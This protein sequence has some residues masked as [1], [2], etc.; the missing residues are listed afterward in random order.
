MTRRHCRWWLGLLLCACGVKEQAPSTS[1][2]GRT[3]CRVEGIQAD[4]PSEILFGDLHVHSAL[5]ID[6]YLQNLP[7]GGRMP[8]QGPMDRCDFARLCAQL[9]FWSINDHPEEQTIDEWHET[10]EAIRLCNDLEGGYTARPAMVSFLGWEWTPTSPSPASDWGHK[11][12]ILRDTCDDTIVARPMSAPQTADSFLSIPEST[13]RLAT[14]VTKGTDPDNADI[15]EE[16]YDRLHRAHAVPLCEAGV[17]SRELPLDCREVADDPGVLYEKLAQWDVPAIVI[18]HGET[19]GAFHP[20]RTGWGAQ[21]NRQMHDPR[22]ERLVEIYSGHGNGEEYRSFRHVN[23]GPDGQLT[24]PEPTVE[25]EPCCYRAGEIARGRSRACREEP[26]GDKCAAEVAEAQQ[27]YVDAGLNGANS[28]PD[29]KPEEW[30]DCGQCRDC[31]QPSF[32]YRPGFSA[33]AAL[34]MTNFDQPDEPFR[35]HFGMIAS[36]DA[37]MAGPGMGYKE[38]KVVTD[39]A[40]SARPEFDKT[41]ELIT[42][43]AFREFERAGAFYYSGGLVAV[44]SRGRDRGAIWDA[45][46]DRR[47]YGTS[48]ERI[49]LWFDL[50]TPDGAAP[51]GAMVSHDT[52]PQFSVRAVGSFQQAPGCPSH[53]EQRAPMGVIER[54]CYG[55]CYNP[56]DVRNRITRI[57]VVKIRPQQLP[58]EPL[59]ALIEDPFAVLPCPQD[60]EGCEV[61]FSDPAYLTDRRPATYY[62]RAIQQPSLQVNGDPLRC[63]RDAEGRCLSS[64]PCPGGYRGEG[65]ECLS[66]AEERAWSSPIFLIPS[67]GS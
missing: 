57:E 65:D 49:L 30:L 32:M 60:T 2:K 37:H 24:C 21:L 18:P 10:T 66:M 5:G 61:T 15:Y 64:R 28:L 27:D 7:L 31:F 56:T 23:E 14:D 16:F 34:A 59:E 40:G 22:F 1:T 4:A 36:T 63:E 3:D 33:Q 39:V 6:V 26:D 53:I 19:W 44:H 42:N 12:V 55:E 47:V 11:N 43:V 52:V 35:Y 45:L 38:R 54:L 20:A 8:D 29:V 25:F 13:L 50:A 62:V 67:R 58:D 9:D 48:G 41:V 51:M 17:H 46:Q